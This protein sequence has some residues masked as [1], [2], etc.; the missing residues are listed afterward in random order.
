LIYIVVNKRILTRLYKEEDG[1]FSNPVCGTVLDKHITNKGAFEFF[2][3]SAN[4]NQG[5][6]TPTKYQVL[7]NEIYNK[8]EIVELNSDYVQ[9]KYY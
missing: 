9:V 8:N 3:I 6:A 4:V 5:T 2:L 1:D 7:Y